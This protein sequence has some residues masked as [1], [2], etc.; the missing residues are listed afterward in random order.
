MPEIGATHESIE[1]LDVEGQS[2]RWW[3]CVAVAFLI[4]QMRMLL[5]KRERQ[6]A[7]VVAVVAV[8]AVVVV[9]VPDVH[10][11]PGRGRQRRASRGGGVFPGDGSGV[12]AT[13]QS[14]NDDSWLL[15]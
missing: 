4:A 3:G 2:P 13:P 14:S 15:N 1:G 6:I 7:S 12:G 9:V 11:L 8:A 10:V 5:C